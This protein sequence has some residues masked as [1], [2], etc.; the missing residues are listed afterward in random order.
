MNLS[1]FPRTTTP[2]TASTLPTTEILM[3][4]ISKDLGELI[5]FNHPLSDNEIYSV[6]GHLF[7]QME[8]STSSLCRRASIFNQLSRLYLNKQESGS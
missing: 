6:E 3:D 5:I 8:S 2:V 7:P 4:D 1:S